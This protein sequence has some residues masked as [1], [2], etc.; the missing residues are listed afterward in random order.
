MRFVNHDKYKNIKHRLILTI[1]NAKT[2][3]QI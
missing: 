2:D 1:F 3:A